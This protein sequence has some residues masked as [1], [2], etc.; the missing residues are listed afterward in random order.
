MKVLMISGS[1]R[2]ESNTDMA[3]AEMKKI[4]DESDIECEVVKIG[5]SNIRGCTDCRK[6]LETGKCVF[7][8]LVNQAAPKFEEAAGI[9]IGSPVK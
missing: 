2:K 9:V 5:S 3:L 4:F 8:D 7:D 6:C 1:P